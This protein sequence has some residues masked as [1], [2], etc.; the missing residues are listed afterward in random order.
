MNCNGRFRSVPMRNGDDD[1]GE[2]DG[3]GGSCREGQSETAT[4]GFNGTG[5][6]QCPC[7]IPAFSDAVSGPTSLC[8]SPDDANAL[9]DVPSHAPE[10]GAVRLAPCARVP[11][12]PAVR[13]QLAGHPATWTIA[14]RP[15][16]R[17]P[18]DSRSGATE[19]PARFRR[20]RRQPLHQRLSLPIC[21]R[22]PAGAA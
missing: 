1:P 7:S 12:I 14:G 4:S 20:Q 10:T 15:A 22:R 18:P 11:A 21:E 6:M 16:R 17:V 2:K 3:S 5:R 19:R 9:D 13:R 8:V